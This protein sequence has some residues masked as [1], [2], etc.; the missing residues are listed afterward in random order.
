MQ[1]ALG[2][3]EPPGTPMMKLQASPMKAPGPANALKKETLQK[4][5]NKDI[6]THAE[7]EIKETSAPGS[8][9]RKPT[10]P[11]KQLTKAEA[12]KGPESQKQVSSAPSQKTKL[13]GQKTGPQTTPDMTSKTGRKQSNATS[14]TQEESG[15]S[16][17]GGPKHQPVAAKPAESISGKMFGFGSS[18]FSSASTL[19]NSAVQDET[20]TPPLSPKIPAAKDTKSPLVQKQEQGKKQEQIQQL[21]ISPLPQSKVEETPSAPVKDAATSLATSKAGQSICPLCKVELNFGS[22]N[23]PNYNN[24]TECKNTVCNQCGFN[25]MPN[26]SEVI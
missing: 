7:S 24:C 20:K 1:R 2:A 13:E 14:T 6:P 11:A 25:P 18:I 16:L 19:I 4:S 3:S 12:V 26:V 17:F 8:P 21:K 23:P 22:K 10:T 5:Q 9:Q 15:G